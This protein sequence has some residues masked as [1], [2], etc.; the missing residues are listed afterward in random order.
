MGPLLEILLTIQP[1]KDIHKDCIKTLE[2][3]EKGRKPKHTFLIINHNITVDFLNNKVINFD[4][5]LRMRFS[6][7]LT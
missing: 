4:Y 1:I 6:K 2:F 3:L 5:K 7:I